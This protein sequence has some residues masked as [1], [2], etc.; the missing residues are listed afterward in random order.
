MTKTIDTLVE[1][2]LAVVDQKGGWD[3]TVSSFFRSRVSAAVDARLTPPAVKRE[4]TLR[5]SSL[6]TPCLRKL[7]Y[8]VNN[9]DAAEPLRPST[10]LKFLYG[11][12]LEELLLSL[13]VAAGHKVEG[14]QDELEIMGIKGHRDCVIDGVTVDVKSASSF[15]FKKFENN[16]LKGYTYTMYGKQITVDAK[17]ADAFGYISQLSSYVYAAK[18]DPLVTDKNRGAFLVIDKVTGDLCLDLYDLTEE[19]KAK[20]DEVAGII[21][22]MVLPVPDR[23]Y[24]PEADGKSGNKKLHKVCSY[25]QFKN[26]CWPGLRTFL[27]SNGPR[28]LTTVNKTP[29]VKEVM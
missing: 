9:T 23:P 11:D 22:A 21:T 20:E 8:S 28:F 15:S 19:I 5:M 26:E 24:A 12:I 17:D 27:Y 18:S 13:A 4:G 7:W 10:K 1:D 14:M 25:C 2:I 29:N 3:V 16:G 6:G